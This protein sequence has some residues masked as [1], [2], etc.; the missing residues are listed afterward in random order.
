VYVACLRNL[1]ATADDVEQ[2]HRRVVLIGAGEN[3]EGLRRGPDGDGVA[4]AAA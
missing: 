1:Q 4:R 2:R 3:G